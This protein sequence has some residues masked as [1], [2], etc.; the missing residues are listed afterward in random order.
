M[1][2]KQKKQKT[3]GSSMEK[4]VCSQRAK[5]NE[6]LIDLRSDDFALDDCLLLLLALDGKSLVFAVKVSR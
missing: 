1:K 3:T 2:K 5:E 6:R 4:K